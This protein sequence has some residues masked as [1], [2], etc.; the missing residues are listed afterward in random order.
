MI[1][2]LTM[3]SLRDRVHDQDGAI[4]VMAAVLASALVLA[5][6]LA[7][8]VGRVAYV[9]RDLQGTTDRGALDSVQV[10]RAQDNRA[11]TE[12][13]DAV[14]E[15]AAAALERNPQTGTQRE[16]LLYR[17]DLGEAT[18]THATDF[19]LVCGGYFDE[20]GPTS[21]AALVSLGILE[22]EDEDDTSAATQEAP[23]T[24]DAADIE[25]NYVDAIRLWTYGAVDYVLAIGGS[26][27]DL[28]KIS[29]A[30]ANLP[31]DPE[32][33]ARG[34]LSVAST[35]ASFEGGEAK[36]LLEEWV[37]GSIS[38]DLVGH[39]GVAEGRVRLGD[40]LDVEPLSV[41][42][43]EELLHSDISVADL[44]Q[45]TANVLKADGDSAS[46]DVATELEGLLD[47]GVVASLGNI[48]LGYDAEDPEGERRGGLA[49]DSSSNSGADVRVD[50]VELAFLALQIANFENAVD[51][52]LDVLGGAMPVTVTVIEGPVFADGY[53]G[54]GADESW[55]TE[56]RTGQIEVDLAVDL[57]ALS[58]LDGS[59]GDA[60]ADAAEALLDVL[61][62]L[63]N[64]VGEVTCVLG[65]CIIDG[66][67]LTLHEVDVTVTAAEGVSRLLDVGCDGEGT[68]RVETF[69]TGA[70]V[71]VTGDVFDIDGDVV[72]MNPDDEVA[73]IVG[74]SGSEVTDFEGP[75][76]DGPV[77]VPEG[78]T[79][80]NASLSSGDLAGDLDDE[81]LDGVLA[82]V[83]DLLEV[84]LFGQ[85]G[86]LH[87]VFAE[88][89]LGLTSA[90][91]MG[92]DIDCTQV[93]LQPSVSGD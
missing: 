4:A 34:A 77:I 15:E 32:Q 88:L 74:D 78:G 87:D 7:V 9:S 92:H 61:S 59:L 69:V 26:G 63:L 16:R 71:A 42:T 41:G 85:H 35:L 67:E 40:L 30:R 3:R 58:S 54:Q 60:V 29:S 68:Q 14:H 1:R 91:V 81:D 47:S 43:M 66:A 37:G 73:L 12:T 2:R 82:E 64:L 33:D 79:P 10:L 23:R 86:V 6:A 11:S 89:G 38:A 75:W 72:R 22:E 44:I 8:D 70:Q 36:A 76:S 5:G 65:I 50:A 84:A 62:G 27:T 51:L 20:D 18:N 45:A 56:A 57:D 19:S 13:L 25:G 21:R 39:R 52:T 83:S 28:H 93:S 48:Q 31:P 90:E 49:L 24:C 80:L 17:V 46:A 55:L 53:P